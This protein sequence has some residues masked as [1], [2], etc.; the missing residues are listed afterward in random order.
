MSACLSVCVC[1]CVGERARVCVCVCVCVDVSDLFN[2]FASVSTLN[3]HHHLTISHLH[4]TSVR[5]LFL[6]ALNNGNNVTGIKVFNNS[7]VTVENDSLSTTKDSRRSNSITDQSLTIS[8]V[9]NMGDEVAVD[10]KNESKEGDSEGKIVAVGEDVIAVAA[11]EGRGVTSAMITTDNVEEV[12]NNNASV[13]EGKEGGGQGEGQGQGGDDDSN[14][15][16]KRS[17]SCVDE[18]ATLPPN[19]KKNSDDVPVTDANDTVLASETAT[20]SAADSDSK[21]VE[22]ESALMCA[23]KDENDDNAE[24]R[25]VEVD[26]SKSNAIMSAPNVRS[27]PVRQSALTDRS[28][29]TASI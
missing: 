5:Y 3:T 14:K 28:A 27:F 29:I 26:K 24:K 17:E 13:E 21:A 19:D 16:R 12:G 4:I 10:S 25:V 9:S 15:K 23:K 8:T 1:G 18:T 22:S 6:D 7:I 20:K 11:E 2:H